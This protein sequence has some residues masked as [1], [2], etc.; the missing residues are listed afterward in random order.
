MHRK[1]RGIWYRVKLKA[2]LRD[3]KCSF[4]ARSLWALMEGFA[5]QDGTSCHPSVE[6]LMRLTGKCKR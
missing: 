6:T 2:M 1:A 5:N 3:T 4:E